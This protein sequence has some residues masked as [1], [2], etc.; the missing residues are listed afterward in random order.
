LLL[1]LSRR[2]TLDWHN[3]WIIG[4]SVNTVI[5]V[6]FLASWFKHQWKNAQFWSV[7]G[8][9]LFCHMVLFIFFL[10]RIEHVPLATYVLT[11]SIELAVFTRILSKVP[12]VTKFNSS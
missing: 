8:L 12:N 11:N 7:L 4:L 1:I 2:S 3:S 10:R 6:A 5:V 9:L